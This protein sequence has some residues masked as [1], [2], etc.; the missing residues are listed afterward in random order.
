MLGLDLDS[1]EPCVWSRLDYVA[2][3]IVFICGRLFSK[4]FAEIL[5]MLLC[6]ITFSP[7]TLE[8]RAYFPSP[9]NLG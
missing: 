3:F 8:G 7:L 2:M 5:P 9:L 4:M 1:P 6:A